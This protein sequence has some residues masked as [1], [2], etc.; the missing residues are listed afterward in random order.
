[1]C[2][3]MYKAM[4][5]LAPSYLQEPCV[6]VSSVITCAALAPQPAVIL[7]YH[8]QD[9]YLACV[10]SVSLVLPPETVYQLT[11]LLLLLLNC[12]YYKY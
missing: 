11:L 10:H 2:L 4:N 12:K 1:M 6:P 8:G 7:W 5:E 3:L 9:D